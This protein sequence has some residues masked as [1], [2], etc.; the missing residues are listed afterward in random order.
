MPACPFCLL[1]HSTKINRRVGTGYPP[2]GKHAD[3][4]RVTPTHN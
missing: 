4:A 3:S 1:V 2:Y